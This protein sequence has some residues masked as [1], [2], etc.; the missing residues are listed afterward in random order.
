MKVRVYIEEQAGGYRLFIDTEEKSI[1][2]ERVTGTDSFPIE[3]FNRVM[4]MAD[5][6]YQAVLKESV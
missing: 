2:F 1:T 4:K 5:T 6:I 3:E